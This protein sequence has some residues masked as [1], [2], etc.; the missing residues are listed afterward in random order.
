MPCKGI[1]AAGKPCRAPEHLVAQETGF[2]QAHGPGGS[3]RM[4]ERGGHGARAQQQKWLETG[5]LDAKT[6]GPLQTHEDAKRWLMLIGQGVLCGQLRD[7]DATAGIRAVSE[8]LKA[9]GERLTTMVV[10]ELQ[11]EVD[12]L[13]AEL[14]GGGQQR[15][16]R[17]L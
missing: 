7:R 8:W 3:E 5:H 9:E 17:S 15:K 2:C 16:L 13:K 14:G 11:A 10:T 4:R 6:L 12:R 1:T